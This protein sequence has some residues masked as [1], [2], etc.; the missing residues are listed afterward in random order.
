MPSM[1]SAC[2]IVST[3]SQITSRET[4]EARM[5]SCPIEMPSD[6]AMVVNSEREAAG[7]S[8]TPGLAC[9]A[10]RPSGMLHGVTSFHDDA[11]AT[12]G[13]SK[14]SSVMPTARSI[15]RAGARSYPSVT[16]RLR[17]RRSVGPIRRHLLRGRNSHHAAASN[18]SMPSATNPSMR[19]YGVAHEVINRTTG[20]PSLWRPVT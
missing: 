15:A 12:C 18:F 10:S 13:L 5:P 11:T 3:E 8:R 16:S 9:C 2:I 19:S 7:A 14:S 4:S 6:T 20:R 17:G 1:R